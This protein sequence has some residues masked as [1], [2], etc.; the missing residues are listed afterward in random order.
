MHLHKPTLSCKNSSHQAHCADNTDNESATCSQH[1]LQ[2]QRCDASKYTTAGVCVCVGVH[3]AWE[4]RLKSIHSRLCCLFL[5]T[6]TIVHWDKGIWAA[7][8]FSEAHEQCR[9]SHSTQTQITCA[10]CLIRRLLSTAVK[11]RSDVMLDTYTWHLHACLGI[12][13]YNLRSMK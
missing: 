5:E 11:Q 7:I 1:S 12:S 10:C 4:S 8:Y 6:R 13:R 3:C 2:L 9:L